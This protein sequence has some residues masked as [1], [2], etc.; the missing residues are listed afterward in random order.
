[1]PLYVSLFPFSTPPSSQPL[2]PVSIN[3]LSLP[4]HPY[5]SLPLPSTSFTKNLLQ[6]RPL[7]SDSSNTNDLESQHSSNFSTTDSASYYTNKNANNNLRLDNIN[8]TNY[9]IH[10]LRT[11]KSSISDIQSVFVGVPEDRRPDPNE[12]LKT[13]LILASGLLLALAY[14]FYKSRCKKPGEIYEEVMVRRCQSDPGRCVEWAAHRVRRKYK[15]H[16]YESLAD[17]TP[18]ASRQV[19][20]QDKVLCWLAVH[21]AHCEE[22]M[23]KEKNKHNSGNEKRFITEEEEKIT[24]QACKKYE[25]RGGKHMEGSK[26]WIDLEPFIFDGNTFI[27][28]SYTPDFNEVYSEMRQTVSCINGQSRVINTA[29]LGR[30]KSSLLYTQV[31]TSNL[32][33]I[34]KKKIFASQYA[35]ALLSVELTQNMCSITAC[36]FQ[37]TQLILNQTNRKYITSISL[38]RTLSCGEIL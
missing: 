29:C 5:P 27:E 9:T 4:L 8:D 18:P 37:P 20:K 3:S 36:Q 24:H 13:G 1:M 11:I 26:T 21:K 22:F 33:N 34:S 7:A 19:M 12:G 32:T 17:L 30:K 31:S 25:F 10:H 38:R 16:L 6:N 15:E 28:E 35:K 2:I 23:D 14:S